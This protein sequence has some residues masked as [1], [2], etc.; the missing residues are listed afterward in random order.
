MSSWVLVGFMGTGGNSDSNLIAAELR[1]GGLLRPGRAD[2][3][4]APFPS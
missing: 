1:K 4:A 3:E 2:E